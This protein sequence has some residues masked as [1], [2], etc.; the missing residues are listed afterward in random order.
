M[1]F[2]REGVQKIEM[3]H[4]C[5]FGKMPIS[6]QFLMKF[7]EK[8]YFKVLKSVRANTMKFESS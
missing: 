2:F 8:S 1:D 7:H 5:E 4:F 6:G 3:Q